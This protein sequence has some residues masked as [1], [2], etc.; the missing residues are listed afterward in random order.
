MGHGDPETVTERPPVVIV[1]VVP[2]ATVKL[3]AQPIALMALS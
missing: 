3:L 2:V 1:E